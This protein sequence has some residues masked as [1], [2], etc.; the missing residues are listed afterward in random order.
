MNPLKPPI[1]GACSSDDHV[2]LWNNKKLVVYEINSANNF[3]RLAGTFDIESPLTGI[4]QQTIFTAE[5][6][7]VT[8]RNFQVSEQMELQCGRF[9]FT[10]S[11]NKGFHSVQSV[12]TLG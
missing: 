1:S 11:R 8:A 6:D 3:A 10:I 5:T 2:A 4:F 9:Y 7:R 12:P